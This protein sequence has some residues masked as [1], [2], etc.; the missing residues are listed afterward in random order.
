MRESCR[1]RMLILAF[2]TATEVATSA[3]VADGEV[4]GE[5][6]SRAVTLLED[7]DALLRQGGA[8]QGDLDALAVGIGPGSFTGV[9]VGLATAR[10]LALALELPV[11]GV[12]T[13]AALAAGA[14]GAT[15]VIDARRREVFV[16]E[17]E[18]RVL[19]PAD[20]RLGA[21]TVCVGNGAVRYRAILEA[22]GAEIPPDG[23]DR[24]LPR[25][26][27]HAQLARDFGPAE[28]VEPLYL[29]LPD[30]DTTVS[31]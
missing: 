11:A 30:A 17:G 1:S 3:L 19:A 12:S 18:P 29:R 2:D 8:H 14:P 4:L 6:V 31:K 20:L 27:F 22:A 13:L 5:R 26:R 7:V 9:R 10:G 21:G 28:A 16:L 15:P 23:D 25:A 24:H